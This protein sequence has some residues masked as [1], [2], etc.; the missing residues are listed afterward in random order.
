VADEVVS[1]SVTRIPRRVAPS[2]IRIERAQPYENVS[3]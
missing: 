2:S 3:P 1:T